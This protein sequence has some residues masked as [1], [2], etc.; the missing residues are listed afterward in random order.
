MRFRNLFL[1]TQVGKNRLNPQQP[2]IS[3]FFLLWITWLWYMFDFSALCCCHQSAMGMLTRT[4]ACSLR[5]DGHGLRT[6]VPMALWGKRSKR[7]REKNCPGCLKWVRKKWCLF[8]LLC[9]ILF[10]NTIA[11]LN[12]GVP[13]SWFGNIRNF[14]RMWL[15]FQ[16]GSPAAAG[17]SQ[18][19][20]RH[21]APQTP[22]RAL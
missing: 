14:Q 15:N 3:P 19:A 9:F 20:L 22:S 21:F 16:T 11:I 13:L 4:L 10:K 1:S 5:T 17:G 7:H 8:F 6:T 2:E 12:I 18:S